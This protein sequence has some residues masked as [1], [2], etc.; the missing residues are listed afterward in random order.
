[1]NRRSRAV[2]ALNCALLA[3]ILLPATAVGQIWDP[4][5]ALKPLNRL[6]IPDKPVEGP[7]TRTEPEMAVYKPPGSGPFAAVVV[8]HT[9]AGIY[10]HIGS[11]TR[12]LV[13]AGYVVLVLDSLTQRNVRRNCDQPL[14][15]PSI[16]G[17]LDAYQALEHLADQPYVDK[18]RIGMLGMSWGGTNAVLSARK[19]VAERL[20]RNRK[21]IRFR[22]SAALYPHCLWPQIT[23]AAGTVDVDFLSIK[24][25]DRPLLVLMGEDDKESPASLCLPGLEALKAKGARISWHVFPHTTHSWDNP[26]SSG[27]VTHAY[28]GGS[29]QYQYSPSA[30]QES[31]QRVLDYFARELGSPTS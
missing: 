9:C 28:F 16:N 1:M 4:L 20:P 11:W 14:P 15:V 3:A 22:A 25:T 18:D 27:Y 19:D 26:Q 8:Q 10:G 6:R 5:R 21:E 2:L 12:E 30:T 24:E 23:T 29:H 31:Y 7:P 13:Q 17:T